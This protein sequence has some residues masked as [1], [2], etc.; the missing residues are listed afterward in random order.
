MPELPEV[1]LAARFL[2]A[3]LLGRIVESV[4]VWD[5]GPEK[6]S[7]YLPARVATGRRCVDVLRRGKQLAL[8]LEGE[9]T[10]AGGVVLRVH[11]GMTGRFLEGRDD[12]R[13][14]FTFTLSHGSLVSF[15]DVR[16][17]ARL[18]VVPGDA[19]D[20]VVFAG[21][22]VDALQARPSDWHVALAGRSLPVK[23]A[24]LEQDRLAGVGNIYACEG[25]FLAGLDPT[26]AAGD[27]DT[28]EVD[29]LRAGIV[30]TMDETLRRESEGIARYVNEGA[31]A[32]PFLVYGREGEPCPRCTTPILRFRQAGRSTWACPTCQHL[33]LVPPH[34]RERRKAT[35][36]T[37]SPPP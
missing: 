18:D 5:A 30:E 10:M 24:L 28:S 26:R 22:G 19:D 4:D 23:P 12:A 29:R 7:R 35:S 31:V 15:A 27:L 25:L 1:E 14:R 3:S 13:V 6:A 17:F 11:L 33:R 34:P 8:R 20:A 36:R 2:R 16:R 37:G 9:G 32:N 21:L